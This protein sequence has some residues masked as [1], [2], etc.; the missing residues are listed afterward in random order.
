[1]S[2]DAIKQMFIDY[3]AQKLRRQIQDPAKSNY[4]RKLEKADGLIDWSQS[5]I[6]ID[7]KIRGLFPWP[8]AYTYLENVLIKILNAEP[9]PLASA[10]KKAGEIISISSAGAIEIQTGEGCL[11]VNQVH[12]EGR[13]KMSADEFA[14]GKHLQPGFIFGKQ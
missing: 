12:P 5:A 10:A 11:L 2:Y 7:Q 8:G 4:A 13:N 6:V 3:R 1:M 14:R 9:K